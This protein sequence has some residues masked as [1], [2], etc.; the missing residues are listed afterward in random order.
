MT[1]LTQP[2]NPCAPELYSERE[3]AAAFEIAKTALTYVASFKT[4]PTPEVYEIW[5]RF[6]EGENDALSEKLGF[7]VNE[8]KS[9]SRER[10]EE[11]HR[12]FFA[13]NESNQDSA[14]TEK[15][16]DELT[17]LESML[18]QQ[19]AIGDD[20]GSAVTSANETLHEDAG[21]E[22]VRDCVEAVLATS[23]TMQSQLFSLRSK[24]ETSQDSVEKLRADFLESQVKL[25]IDP[26]TCVGNRRFFDATMKQSLEEQ[27]D[28]DMHRVLMLVDLDKFKE[29]N[30][31]FGHSAGDEVLRYVAS[32]LARLCTGA[33]VARYGGDEFAVFCDVVDPGEGLDLGNKLCEHFSKSRLTLKKTGQAL[34]NLTLSIGVSTLRDDDSGDDWF[35]RADK[36]LYQAKQSG[37][38]R[39]M[40]ERRTL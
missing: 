39:V 20:F 40:A 24:L 6:A 23:E 29:I 18:R 10:I 5:Y 34:G 28:R 26:L 2:H 37:R 35:D 3:Y 14:I 11:I 33:S 25:Q 8:L 31:T 32:E 36:L 30:D 13:S 12:E 21:P 17:G 9:I 16:A 1:T 27:S 38:S 15:L 22:Q 19:I 4:P 7:V